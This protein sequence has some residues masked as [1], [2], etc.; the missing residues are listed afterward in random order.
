MRKFTQH[1]LKYFN[2]GLLPYQEDK[3]IAGITDYEQ[4]FID[5]EIDQ[6]IIDF[7]ED[8]LEQLHD[9]DSVVLS[10]TKEPGFKVIDEVMRT[11]HYDNGQPLTTDKDSYFDHYDRDQDYWGFFDDEVIDHFELD[12]DRHLVVVLEM[13][14]PELEDSLK[15]MYDG[16]SYEHDFGSTWD[17]LSTINTEED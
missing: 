3:T 12:K 9:V 17:E 4:E 10:D 7:W 6:K 11:L 14:R 15:Q 5:E 13:T 1:D 16:S 8:F 2:D